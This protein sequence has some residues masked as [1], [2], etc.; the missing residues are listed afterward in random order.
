MRP[1]LVVGTDL[2]VLKAILTQTESKDSRGH[3]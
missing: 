3:R 1:G 2:I